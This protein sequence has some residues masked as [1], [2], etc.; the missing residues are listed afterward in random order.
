MLF[1]CIESKVSGGSYQKMVGSERRMGN[2]ASSVTNA[3]GQTE[4]NAHHGSMALFAVWEG[5]S[6]TTVQFRV[7]VKSNNTNDVYFEDCSFTAIRLR[8]AG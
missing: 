1:A 3:N 6:G 5:A 4:P 2:P 8:R 7:V